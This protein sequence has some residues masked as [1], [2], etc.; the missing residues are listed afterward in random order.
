MDQVPPWDRA[1]LHGGGLAWLQFEGTE[2]LNEQ[3]KKIVLDFI[4]KKV[5]AAWR[6]G[7]WHG[8]C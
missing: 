7:V 5:T 4:I 8:P 3:N 2:D 1:G 6:A